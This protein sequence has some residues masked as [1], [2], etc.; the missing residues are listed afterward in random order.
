MPYSKNYSKQSS[1]VISNGKKIETITEI[2]NNVKSETKI[3]TDL[4]TG[5]VLKSSSNSYLK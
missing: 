2:H 3:Q 4:K 1:V 5:K